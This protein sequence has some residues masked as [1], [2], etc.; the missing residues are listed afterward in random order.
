[1]HR[2]AFSLVR[3]IFALA[4]LLPLLASAQTLTID[5]D[6]QTYSTL[7]NTTVTMTGRSDLR[8]TGTSSPISGSIINLNSSDAW[9]FMTNILP[10]VVNSTY[11]SQIRVNGAAAALNTNCRLVEY[12]DGT[13]VI[14]HASTFQP[15]TVYT[16]KLFT[17]SS[18]ALSLYTAYDAS[19]LGAFN[20][21]ISS[22]KLKRG[23]MATIAQN[24]AGTGVSKCYVA[25]DGDIEVSVLPEDLNN[26]VS[27]V[28]IFPWRW[29]NKKGIAGNIA[30]GL[31][32]R[33]DYNWN[34]DRNSTLD[35]EYVPIRQTRWWPGLAQDWKARGSNHLL[36]YNEPDSTSQSDIAVGDAIWS[37][38]DL[39]G[40]GLRVGSPAVTD[41]GLGGWLYPFM[42]Q[43]DADDLRVDF[44]AVHYY[45]CY[46]P[47]NPS[48]AATQFYNFLKGIY[49]QTKRPIWITEWN[50]GANWTSCT[51][52]TSAQHQA[53]ISAMMDMLESTP[54]VERYSLYNWVEDVRR[55][56]WDDGSLTSS[57]TTYRDKL[58]RLGYVQEIPETP[59]PVSAL[60]RFESDTR[61][62]S[63]NGHNAIL[64]GTAKFS[65]GKTGQA[66]TLS[67]S[68]DDYVTLSPRLGDSTDLTFGA[69][70][71]WNG[72]SNWQRI[73]DL[74]DLTDAYMFLT[75][76]SNAGTMR[77]AI[78][79]K[80]GNEQQLNSP[81]ALPTNAWTH[82]AVTISGN[83][84]K[85]FVNG[86]LVATNTNMTTNPVDIGTRNNFLGKSQF[87]ADPLFAGKLDDVQFLP[88]AAA[89]TTVV[90]MMSNT[91]PQFTSTAISGGTAVQGV[92]Y[93][94]SIAGMATDA[95][96][97]DALTYS[98]GSGPAWLTVAASGALS[99]TPTFDDE[100]VHEFVVYVTDASG[101]TASAVLNIS[102][103]SVSGNGTWTSA[104]TG[105]TWSEGTKWLNSFPANGGGNSANFGTLDITSNLTVTLD[106]SR[107]IGSL[108]FGDTSGTQNW[109]LNNSGGATLTLDAANPTITVNQNTATIAAPLAGTAGFMKSGVGTLVLSGDNSLSGTLFIDTN[110][111]SGSSGTVRI[112]NPD[113]VT[114]LTGISIRNNNSG[115]ST[116]ELDGTTRDIAASA[117][118]S[119]SG[120]NVAVPAIRNL[121]GN[122]TLSGGLTLYAGGSNYLLQSDAGALTFGGTITST[123]GGTRA[124]TFQ[125]TGNFNVS[126]AILDGTST[127]TVLALTKTGSGTLTLSGVNTYSGATTVMGGTLSVSGGNALPNAGA[128]TL[129]NNAGVMLT[130]GS[131]ETIGSLAG[132]GTSG[133]NVALN[134]TL[135]TGGD[136][137]STTFAG[138]LSGVGGLT[139]TGTGTLTLT[140]SNSYT[141][142]TIV[143]GGVIK[144]QHSN[145]FG[146]SGVVSQSTGGGTPRNAGIQ[147]QGNTTIPS[148]VS[149]ITSNDGTGTV[150]YAIAN[151]SGNNTING[152]VT[153]T[154]GGGNTIIQSD[155]GA[156]TLAGTISPISGQSRTLVLQGAST[157]ANTVSGTIQNFS[158]TNTMS[159]TKSGAGT[160][161][162]SGVNT[163]TGTTSVSAGTFVLNGSVAS[164]AALTSA[165]GTTLSGT[166]STASAVTIS[167]TH[168]PGDPVGTQSFTGPLSYAA[169]ARLKWTLAS[170]SNSAGSSSK[171]A[172]G[173]V[174]ITAGTVI[175]FV[176]N[177]TGSTVALNDAFWTQARSWTILTASSIS[178]TF[179][180][181]DVSADPGGRVISNYGALSLSQTATAVT[182]TFTPYTPQQNWKR[183]NFGAN[184]NNQTVSG[185]SVDRD[186]DGLS[187]LLE[188]ALA[189]NPNTA[190]PGAAPQVDVAD[191]RLTI[192]FTRNAAATDATLS[193]LGSDNPSG[194]WTELARSTAG[195]AFTAV[196]GGVTVTETGTDTARSV[197]V[198]DLYSA[199]DPAHPTRFL[200]LSV[201]H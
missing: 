6:I 176:L 198:S 46:D 132:G 129:S 91:P 71:Y 197:Q 22:F 196:A 27:F 28:R 184:W 75:P 124:L 140:G 180:L 192:T 87:S 78:K 26:S 88:Y 160:W 96:A 138:M 38:P 36:G 158:S 20:D 135:T 86:A 139:K 146:S 23:Y 103:P 189:S 109:T 44:V 92:A 167:G 174:N 151:I 45:R 118:A 66:V 125:G 13:V 127:V 200:R 59:T 186:N 33:W 152:P 173:A 171:V 133:G 85:L 43:A 89:D 97:G 134:A 83:T 7:T 69:W 79:S 74:G 55:V 98:K 54:F 147:L 195:A 115:S 105:G 47:A 148:S 80:G 35:V 49:D 168:A 58:S 90:K 100:G 15:M 161:I 42:T 199:G 19:S 159:I 101:A 119:L 10:S 145:A 112:N 190:T 51:D 72:G 137:T 12:G 136:N 29:V 63:G 178:G 165:A 185:D 14:P 143:S 120:R 177:S 18:M 164:P 150:P 175:D 131:T 41:G 64:H 104:T 130:I 170:N 149:F 110:V 34:I 188:Y 123:A 8:V 76:S 116:L 40:T 16:G 39:L 65:V 166:G 77:F 154:V 128:V 122:N 172:A 157:A 93:S 182:L 106:R 102:L 24:P 53:A 162:L 2:P 11:L 117:P 84:G 32:V 3:A 62:S 156:L 4:W 82:V 181:G 155:S 153:L 94:G 67:G 201:E 61:D 144:A 95:D 163:Y 113:S 187:N 56:K 114:D 1:M 57:G 73:F 191:G 68:N 193:V 121:A 81:N 30:S 183:S 142:G 50:Q 17:G 21:N 25:A 31:N 179:T 111:A 169:T 108:V 37:W 107:S 60:Y 9:F 52:P 194:P 48:G 126:G 5:N 141:G 99:G 70:V